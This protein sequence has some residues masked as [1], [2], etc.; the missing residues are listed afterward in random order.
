MR[1]RAS[2]ETVDKS[3]QRA[4]CLAERASDARLPG[5]FRRSR[6]L[7]GIA[8]SGRLYSLYTHGEWLDG[9]VPLERD[10][11]P[12][13]QHYLGSGTFEIRRHHVGSTAGSLTSGRSTEWG[14]ASTMGT[15]AYCEVGG[16]TCIFPVLYRSPR[17]SPRNHKSSGNSSWREEALRDPAGTPQNGGE[18]VR[19]SPFELASVDFALGQ[20]DEGF[21]WLAKAFQDRG[22]GTRSE[23]WSS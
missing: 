21:E 1:F 3:E 4:V 15:A 20:T 13:G 17:R 6:L 5:S 9:A 10:S 11:R 7:P 23:R 22:L 2:N 18:A 16:G 14:L 12:I 19:W 8:T